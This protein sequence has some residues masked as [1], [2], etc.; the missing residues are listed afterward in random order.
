MPWR[1]AGFDHDFWEVFHLND[2]AGTEHDGAFNRV[3]EFADVA[4][5]VVI[6]HAG[7]RLRRD[8]SDFALALLAVFR[9]EIMGERRQVFTT[10]AQ[11]GQIQANYVQPVI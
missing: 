5:P 7:H 1:W 6:H 8:A 11:R 10:F 4:G 2:L 3:L 9:R